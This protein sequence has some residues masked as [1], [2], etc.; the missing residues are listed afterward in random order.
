MFYHRADNRDVLP[1]THPGDGQ[2]LVE[3]LSSSH[4]KTPG[5]WTVQHDIEWHDPLMSPPYCQITTGRTINCAA[6][7]KVKE[8]RTKKVMEILN[9]VG[10]CRGGGEWTD[11]TQRREVIGQILGTDSHIVLPALAR[12]LSG[13]CSALF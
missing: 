1:L 3:I 12:Q 5:G 6:G 8:Q 2:G 4:A 7:S 13:N 11:T 9:H 10:G